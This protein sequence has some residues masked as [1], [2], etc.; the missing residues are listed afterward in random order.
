VLFGADSNLDLAQVLYDLGGVQFGAFKMPGTAGESPIYI[1]PRVLLSEPTMLRRIARLLAIEIRADTSRRRPRLA[2]FAAV[3]GV[4]MGGLNLA[5]AYALESGTPLVFVRDAA[6]NGRQPVE[7]HV[8][9][10]Q[11][12]LVLDDLMTGG[13]SLLTIM[14]QLEQADMRVRDAIVLIDREQGGVERL[15]EHGYHVTPILRLKTM[16]NY[17]LASDFIDHETFERCMAYL[18]EHGWHRND[19]DN[20]DA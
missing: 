10:G 17:Y 16:L 4:P 12:V 14:E 3:A 19:R 7:G 8:F 18:H 11:T 1:N 2:S 6:R 15:H 9:T 20:E 13:R 5:T